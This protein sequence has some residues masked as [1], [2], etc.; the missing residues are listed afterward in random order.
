MNWSTI[1]ETDKFDRNGPSVIFLHWIYIINN[2]TYQSENGSSMLIC[3]D[4]LKSKVVSD[5]EL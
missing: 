4:S 5:I 3:L 2:A 1:I